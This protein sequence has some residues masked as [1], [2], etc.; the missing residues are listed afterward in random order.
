MRQTW[1]VK[2]TIA[3]ILKKIPDAKC[4]VVGLGSTGNFKR[5]AHDKR[6]RTVDDSDEREWC[7]V[8]AQSHVVIG[9]HGSN[10]LLPTAHAAGCVEILPSDRYGNIVQDI[11]VRYADRRQLYFYRFVDQYASPKS[12]AEKAISI[13]RNFEIFERNMCRNTYYTDQSM[14]FPTDVRRDDIYAIH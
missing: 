13:I 11:S 10:M 2:R 8:Y 14:I 5:Y 3:L 7:S 9:V 12:V 1:L 4:Y 6:K